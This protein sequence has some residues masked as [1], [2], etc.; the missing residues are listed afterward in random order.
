M[1]QTPNITDVYYIIECAGYQ[2][3]LNSNWR[4]FLEVGFKPYFLCRYNV[5]RIFFSGK[6]NPGLFNIYHLSDMYNDNLIPCSWLKICQVHAE[7]HDL[8]FVSSSPSRG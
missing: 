6:E 4:T 8:V 1:L 3:V 5:L 2:F 7:L